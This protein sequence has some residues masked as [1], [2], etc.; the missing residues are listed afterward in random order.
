MAT[1]TATVA[2]SA[3]DAQESD[4]VNTTNGTTLNANFAH[5]IIGLR[6]TGA[7]VPPGSTINSS[8]LTLNLPNATWDDPDVTIRGAGEANPA[9]FTTD[10]DHL[11][12]RLKTSAAVTWTATAIGTGARD[13]PELKTLVEEMTA[14]PGW[15]SG[16][17][18]AF[19]IT[20]SAASLLRIYGYDNGS[21]AAQLTIDYTPPAGAAGSKV[22]RTRLSTKVGGLLCSI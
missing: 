8:K 10:T 20:G 3:D 5:Q 22:R 14:I 19:Y 16:N 13:T 2:A 15:A 7:T 1:F 17:A 18:M 11:T 21:G 4:H 9:A 6:F 12:N